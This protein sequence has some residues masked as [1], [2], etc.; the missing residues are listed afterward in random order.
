MICSQQWI[1]RC[2]FQGCDFVVCYVGAK[3]AEEPAASI[4]V[5]E[6]V[7]SE[8]G[9]IDLPNCNMPHFSKV[10]VFYFL[11]DEINVYYIFVSIATE[12]YTG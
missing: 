8:D 10:I 11:M 9:N 7:S 5:V 6:E 3:V 1:L 2:G 12:A 4:S